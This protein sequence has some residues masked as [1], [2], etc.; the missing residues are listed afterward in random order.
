M[1]YYTKQLIVRDYSNKHFCMLDGVGLGWGRYMLWAILT[2]HLPCAW[3]H[4]YSTL[5]MSDQIIDL[6][7]STLIGLLEIWKSYRCCGILGDHLERRWTFCRNVARI[8]ARWIYRLSPHLMSLLA[9]TW[10]SLAYV[11]GY[12]HEYASDVLRWLLA[13]ECVCFVLS[14]VFVLSIKCR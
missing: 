1:V 11:Y 4:R 2:W 5:I 3:W 13:I 6:A 9:F 14:T 8:A 10:L 12:V 7:S